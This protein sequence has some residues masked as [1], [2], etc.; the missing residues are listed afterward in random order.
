ML[1]E[2]REYKKIF[3]ITDGFVTDKYEIELVLNLIENIGNEGID[4]VSIGVGS[5]PNN[6]KEICPN[7]C[8]S[9]TI[10][11]IHDSYFLSLSIS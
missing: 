3:L 5:F 1:L 6:L 2:R 7:C 8:N 9:P 4:L 11:T 10:R